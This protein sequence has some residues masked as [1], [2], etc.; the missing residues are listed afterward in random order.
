M[1]WPGRPPGGLGPLEGERI[2]PNGSVTRMLQPIMA[3]HRP[4][5]PNGMARLVVAGGGYAHIEA[6]NESTPA[7]R[8]LHSLGV[9]GFELFY[10]LPR[11]G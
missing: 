3:V 7:C 5:Q 11:H 10:R 2:N 4:L 6:G 1:L 9:T 8:W